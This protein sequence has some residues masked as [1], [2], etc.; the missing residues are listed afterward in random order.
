MQTLCSIL[1]ILY[2]RRV[3]SCF[4]IFLHQ[5]TNTSYL[6]YVFS[7]YNRVLFPFLF[8][9]FL[10]L[11]HFCSKHVSVYFVFAF[12]IFSY[13]FGHLPYFPFFLFCFRSSIH[14]KFFMGFFLSFIKRFQFCCSSFLFYFFLCPL[15]K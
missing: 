3:Y 12:P 4:F 2:T 5:D 13:L 6:D 11:I 14:I 8:S 10:F 7:V 1:D 9:L 15:S